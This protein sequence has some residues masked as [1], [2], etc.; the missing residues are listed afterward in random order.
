MSI[1]E[2][3]KNLS[4]DDMD[5]ILS[6]F[7]KQKNEIPTYSFSQIKREKL[8]ELVDIERKLG[9]TVFKEWFESD[10]QISESDTL[11][12]QNLLDKNNELINIYHEEDLK[13]NFIAP[14]INRVDFFMLD[15]NIRSFY[16]EKISFKSENFIFR[17]E[18]DF[19]VSVGIE[20]AKEPHFFIQEFKKG[21]DFSDPEP[22]LLAELIS[23]VELNRWNSI[24]GAYIIGENWNFVTLQKLGDKKY[25]YFVS[26]T[27][28]STNIESL[29]EIYKNLLF[30]KNEI[31]NSV[32]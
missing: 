28:N 5:Y 18:V 17:G 10:F 14:L 23:A 3:V 1:L 11:F 8:D 20:K 30:I 32:K 12:L 15:K 2:F 21:R 29:K 6:E 9:Q 25:Q 19:T 13:V 24:R 26:R 31:K 4:K 22:Q 7:Q 16:N 27:F